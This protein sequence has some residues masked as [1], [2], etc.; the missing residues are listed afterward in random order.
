MRASTRNG[1]S[2]C[3]ALGRVHGEHGGG[4]LG[5]VLLPRRRAPRL[6]HRQGGGRARRM[7]TLG[8][9][10]RKPERERVGG[11]RGGL[12]VGVTI[13]IVAAAGILEREQPSP[14]RLQLL[15]LPLLRPSNRLQLCWQRGLLEPA[16]C[17]IPLSADC[18]AVAVANGA[19]AVLPAVASRATARNNLARHLAAAAA[20][21]GVVV[22]H[23]RA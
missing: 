8:G 15:H 17:L 7:A 14:L 10:H 3:G 6:V 16:V 12:V 23:W 21:C 19:H 1:R 18:Q 11:L 13:E 4:A 22:G 9:V 20:A 2:G 5:R